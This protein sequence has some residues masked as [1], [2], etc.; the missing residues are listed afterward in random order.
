MSMKG[1]RFRTFS[2]GESG[3]PGKPIEGV[4]DMAGLDRSAGSIRGG[5]EAALRE[6]VD[7]TGETTGG[8]N[9][10]FEC[11]FQQAIQCEG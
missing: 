8:L 3:K 7:G 2:G 1:G 10:K 11:V 4:L 6:M 5:F 9:E